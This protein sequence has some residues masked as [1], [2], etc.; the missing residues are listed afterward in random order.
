MEQNIW[1]LGNT[2][3]VKSELDID[4][5]ENPMNYRRGLRHK[6]RETKNS[7]QTNRRLPSE[8]PL[9][10]I[11]EEPDF[12]FE[13][14]F[15]DEKEVEQIFE[16]ESDELE[17]EDDY[18]YDKPDPFEAE[19]NS[20]FRTYEKASFER[21]N[22]SEK[23]KPIDANTFREQIFREHSQLYLEFVIDGTYSFSKI[24]I[25]VYH[26]LEN[27]VYEIE[28]AAMDSGEVEVKYGLTVFGDQIKMPRYENSAWYTQK[29]DE[30]L[31]SVKD[32]VFVGG[33]NDGRETIN[34]GIECALRKLENS[35]PAY[36]NRAIV[37]FTDSIPENEQDDVYFDDIAD[38]PNRGIRFALVYLG[39]REYYGYFKLVDRNGNETENG[40]NAFSEVRCISELLGDDSVTSIRNL[41]YNLVYQ[42]SIR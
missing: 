13:P 6:Y 27:A 41:V 36:A 39:Q 7:A 32:I 21:G 30:F 23:V 14:E 29:K 16:D 1:I 34:E 18:Q 26:A 9:E 19:K 12:E 3:N 8:D 33:S 22:V 42:T 28:K 10:I 2:E 31:N 15:Y 5:K 38:C 37:V 20:D 40:K 35:T 11:K 24:F 4:W 25:P 17:F